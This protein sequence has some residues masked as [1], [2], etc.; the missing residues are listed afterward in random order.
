MNRETPP[1][2]DRRLPVG[3]EIVAGGGVHF[4][5]WAPDHPALTLVLEDDGRGRAWEMAMVREA[6]GYRSV[7][8]P[9]AGAGA[10]YRFRV[11]G[12]D[13]LLQDPASRFQPEGPHGPSEVIDPVRLRVDGRRLARGGCRGA[14]ALRDARRHLHP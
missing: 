2:A 13:R 4:R 12:T 6:R 14:G 7:L 1:A 10:R 3:A 8:A 11:P 5:V 9:T